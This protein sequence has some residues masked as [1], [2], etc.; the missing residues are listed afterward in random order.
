MYEPWES[1]VVETEVREGFVKTGT[2]KMLCCK[3]G[4]S[5][6][7]LS[8]WPFCGQIP[9]PTDTI[10]AS[11][12]SQKLNRFRILDFFRKKFYFQRFIL[13]CFYFLGKKAERQLPPSLP[14]YGPVCV[15]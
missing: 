11:F 12:E 8:L 9:G 1:G 15:C 4:S 14:W 10:W 3:A 5:R 2:P 13:V 7:K 6:V